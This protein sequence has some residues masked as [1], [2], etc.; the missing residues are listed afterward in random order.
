MLCKSGTSSARPKRASWN[1]DTTAVLE[2]RQI[3]AACTSSCS[4]LVGCCGCSAS[5]SGGAWK[6]GI[7]AKELKAVS[8][9]ASA[10]SRVVAATVAATSR[11]LPVSIQTSWMLVWRMRAKSCGSC[12]K[13]WLRQNG[14]S[15]HEPQNSCKNMPKVRS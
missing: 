13:N 4:I 12:S 9:A 15:I 14:C 10:S 6:V 7:S 1:I 8:I 2:R 3:S 11:P 5:A